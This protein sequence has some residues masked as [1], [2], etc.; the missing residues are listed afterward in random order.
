[1]SLRFEK[2]Q[3][4]EIGSPVFVSLLVSGVPPRP[5]FIIMTGKF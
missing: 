1:M 2:G 3:K 4:I 5:P